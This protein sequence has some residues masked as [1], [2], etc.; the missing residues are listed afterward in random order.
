MVPRSVNFDLIVVGGGAGGLGAARAARWTGANVAI[1][2]D[3]P[4]GGDCTFTGCVPSKTLLAAAAQGASFDEAMARVR[5][6]VDEI[7]ATET[8]DVLRAEGATVIEGRAHLT[9]HDTVAVGPDRYT[10]PRVIVA[11]GSRP[12][13]P[14]IPGLGDVEVLTNE[15]V[16]SLTAAPASIG[17]IGGGPIGCEIAQALHGLGV[18]VELFEGAPRL[19]TKE[20]PEASSVVESAL[21]ARGIGVHTSAMIERVESRPDGIALITDEGETLVERLLIAVGRVP[22]S[23]GLGLEELGVKLDARGHIETD[24]R[25]QTATRGVFAVG[26]VTGKLP[27]THAA[28]EMGRLAA[29]NALR[30]GMR[31]RFQTKWI[32][33]ATFTMPEVARVGLTEAE[34]ATRGGRVAELPLSEM[35]RAITDGQTNGFIKLI[36]GPKRLTR[37]AFGGEIIG[38]TIV[39]PRA[40]EMIHE[41][42]LAMRTRMFAG[43]LAQTVHAYPTWSYGIQKTAGQFFGEVEGRTAR[44]AKP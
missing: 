40:G 9:T 41:A 37:N 23:A 17:I 2:N 42:A 39:A 5:S 38:A 30:R 29:G 8:A 24:D 19:L 13:I 43:R 16:F 35:D 11:T 26:D 1:V 20:E 28:D 21:R 3:G 31:G 27:F 10:A 7:A 34:A 15:E 44:P 36:A 22:N 25:L 14:P 18:A 33:W 12:F 6:T 32:P 4:L